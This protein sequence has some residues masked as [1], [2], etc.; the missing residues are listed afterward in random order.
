MTQKE[1]LR[2]LID[3]LTTELKAFEFEPSYKE[4]GF[5]KRTSTNIFSYQFL[6]YN[7]TIIK[8]GEKGFL[9][10]PYIWIN[11]KA[12]EK[13]YKEITLNTE[14][15]TDTNFITIGNSIANIIANPD[16]LYE[17]RN[18][19]LDLRIYEEE[20]ISLVAEQ[21]IRKFKEVA[22]PYC[23]NNS[24]VAMVDKII[25]ARPNEYKV[26]MS[27][28]NYRIL[29]GIIAA[30]L[31]NNPQLQELIGIYEK[32]IIDRDMYNVTDEMSRLKDI[33]PRIE[34]NS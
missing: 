8:T 6:V 18:R 20:H 9:I 4:Q 17:N 27:N 22:F 28:D 7:R 14:L 2:K 30:K 26:H 12:I 3:L 24:T 5:I 11:V 19:S 32:Q 33:L 15:K 1:V 29:K 31:N 23:L 10:E 34:G 16:G 25:N 13:I 21:L